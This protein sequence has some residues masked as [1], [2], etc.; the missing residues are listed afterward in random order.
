MIIMNKSS[1]IIDFQEYKDR[2]EK[3][4]IES[5]YDEAIAELSDEIDMV[6][7]NIDIIC[8]NKEDKVIILLQI[9]NYLANLVDSILSPEE[10]NNE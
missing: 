5:R 10:H 6:L 3:K 4:S 8:T 1:N 9:R 2:L 7:D